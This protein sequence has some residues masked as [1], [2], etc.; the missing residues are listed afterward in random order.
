[1]KATIEKRHRGVRAPWARV[2]VAA[3]LGL[4][5]AAGP[6][7]AQQAE[8]ATRAESLR[9]QREAKAQTLAPPEK[10]GLTAKIWEFTEDTYGPSATQWAGFS[11][12]FGS[13]T[14]GGGFALGGRYRNT[15]LF[16]RRA[17]VDVKAL[18]SFKQYYMVSG[19]FRVPRIGGT[20]LFAAAEFDQ[21]DTRKRTSSA[22]ART[23][24]GKT[25]RTSCCGIGGSGGASGSICSTASSSEARWPGSTPASGAVRT[26]ATRRLSSSSPMPRPR[27]SRASPRSW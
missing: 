25:D 2:V 3:L 16:D 14:A 5:A 7:R 21:F 24:P 13:V 11:P 17:G 8:P 23:R 4:G 26:P 22:W 18:G 9:Q 12:S 15:L 6:V 19:K 20:P 10:P 27:G 1:M